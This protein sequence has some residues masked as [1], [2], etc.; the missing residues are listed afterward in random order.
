MVQWTFHALLV[1]D[2]EGTVEWRNW[3][4]WHQHFDRLTPQQ[5]KATHLYSPACQPQADFVRQLPLLAGRWL[6]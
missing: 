5:T 2:A 6:M 3:S 4:Y 1:V